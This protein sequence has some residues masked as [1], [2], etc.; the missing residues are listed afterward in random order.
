MDNI[1]MGL[2]TEKDIGLIEAGS[3]SIDESFKYR[4]LVQ[5]STLMEKS[6]FQ[7]T[8]CNEKSA[9]PNCTSV[10]K[11][12]LSIKCNLD[13][14]N[15]LLDCKN[16]KSI[17][18]II[19][20]YLESYS[21]LPISYPNYNCAVRKSNDKCTRQCEYLSNFKVYFFQM[22]D[23]KS[24]EPSWNNYCTCYKEKLSIMAKLNQV[25]RVCE[26]YL[27]ESSFKFINFYFV[28][29]LNFI[30]AWFYLIYK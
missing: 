1:Y 17:D 27:N 20:S 8:I 12:D 4:K 2:F 16:S 7:F 26:Y 13:N 30:S 29:G 28:L 24:I 25:I 3:Y 19:L 11:Y 22:N 23:D 15:F 10:Y 14:E 6:R 21:R 18:F 9:L 5:Y